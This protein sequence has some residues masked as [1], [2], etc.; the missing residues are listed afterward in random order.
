M[1]QMY[2]DNGVSGAKSRNQR[3]GLDAMLKDAARGRFDVVPGL[4]ALDRLGRSLIDLLDT[5][6]ELDAAPRWRFR[7]PPASDRYDDPR[8]AHVLSRH[9][10]ICRVRAWDDP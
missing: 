6:G 9:R 3:P 2:A 5:L 10:S 7:P 4:G 1:I 8:R